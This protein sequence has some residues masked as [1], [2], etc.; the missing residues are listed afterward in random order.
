MGL[1]R[2]YGE[3]HRHDDDVVLPQLIEKSK[4]TWLS[5]TELCVTPQSL[6]RLYEK[7]CA[8]RYYDGGRY[9]YR[10]SQHAQ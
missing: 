8:R 4:S 10:A 9:R 7:G 3:K 2:D 6:K 5:A 1:G